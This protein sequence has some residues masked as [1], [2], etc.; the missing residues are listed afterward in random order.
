MIT[1][2]FFKTKKIFKLPS[3]I[4]LFKEQL[5]EKLEKKKK[6]QQHSE[7]TTAKKRNQEL[8]FLKI[9]ILFLFSF[10]FFEF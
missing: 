2:D 4:S 3:S 9:R 10:F 8:K 5:L 6:L 1:K 7:V